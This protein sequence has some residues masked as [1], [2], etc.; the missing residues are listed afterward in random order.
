M[1]RRIRY[2][3]EVHSGLAQRHGGFPLGEEHVR[4][5]SP[6]HASLP[7]Y[8]ALGSGRRCLRCRYA[9][10]SNDGLAI[11]RKPP[12]LFLL[13]PCPAPSTTDMYLLVRQY[14]PTYVLLS[15]SLSLSLS[16]V[17]DRSIAPTRSLSVALSLTRSLA[18]SPGI[19]SIVRAQLVRTPS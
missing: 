18:R 19:A 7:F 3:M 4:I 13:T 6:R 12:M 14:T 11:R 16:L 15:L 5:E 8:C 17:L 9:T 1:W 10:D 2:Y